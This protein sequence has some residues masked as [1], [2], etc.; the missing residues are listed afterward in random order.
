[1]LSTPTEAGGEPTSDASDHL[2]VGEAVSGR[3]RRRFVKRQGADA[4]ELFDPSSESWRPCAATSC[5]TIWTSLLCATTGR[6]SCRGRRTA[7][8]TCC[9]RWYRSPRLSRFVLGRRERLVV[10]ALMSIPVYLVLT[11]LR[12]CWV[13][14]TLELDAAVRATI[15]R[16]GI[17]VDD[18]IVVVENIVR[19]VW[20]AGGARGAP[21]AVTVG[22]VDV[23]G[24][25]RPLAMWPWSPRSLPMA[26]SS[27]VVSMAPGH[28]VDPVGAS[29]ATIPPLAARVVVTGRR[30]RR[31]WAGS[32]P[33]P[34]P[35]SGGL[36]DVAR[37]AVP[38]SPGSVRARR[39]TSLAA[40]SGRSRRGPCR[41][42][43][44]RS[45]SKMLALRQTSSELQAHRPHAD[46][47]MLESIP[48][49]PRRWLISRRRD[50]YVV[51]AES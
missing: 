25:E 16:I 41:S 36:A 8:A 44:A 27:L 29:A 3:E 18:A 47:M 50:R 31:S 45:R 28:V 24:T 7:P 4:I 40:S 20:P 11:L 48:R 32:M 9:S 21:Q 37:S 35:A 51:G 5:R 42:R 14:D 23:L 26:F 19:H 1:M 6:W 2:R 49:P 22:A 13:R 12:S 39:W 46:Y 30:A 43:L 15:S 33:A 10:A 38:W 17:L 34:A